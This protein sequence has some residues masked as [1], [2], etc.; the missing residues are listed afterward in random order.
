MD[1]QKALELT[2]GLK[3]FDERFEYMVELYSR[4]AKEAKVRFDAYIAEGFTEQQAL[5]LCKPS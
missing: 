5:F 4:M 1:K 3:D 2:Q